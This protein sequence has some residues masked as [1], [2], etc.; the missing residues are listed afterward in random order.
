MIRYDLI[1]KHDHTFEAWFSSSAD[2]DNQRAKRLVQCPVCNSA[3]VEKAIMAPKVATSRQKDTIAQKQLAMM[4]SVAAKIR[5]EISTNCEDVGDKFAEEARAI[6][7]GEKAE[8]GIYGQA[9]AR[10][11]EALQ[12]EGIAALPLPDMLAPTPAKKKLN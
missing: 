4:N 8:R 12:E 3:K 5:E 2:Y 10:E 6:H 11:A 7:Y 1:C 9:T